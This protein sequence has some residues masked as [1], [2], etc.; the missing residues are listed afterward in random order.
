MKLQI[1]SNIFSSLN[2]GTRMFSRHLNNEWLHNNLKRF[3]TINLGQDTFENKAF[4]LA[5]SKLT[6]FMNTIFAFRSNE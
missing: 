5:K 6:I 1:I 4:F 2:I 3:P